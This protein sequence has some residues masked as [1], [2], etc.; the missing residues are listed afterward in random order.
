M[1]MS[2][3]TPNQPF[4]AFPVPS[5]IRLREVCQSDL[6]PLFRHQLDPQANLMAVA[7]PRDLAT[8]TAHWSKILS[9]PGVVARA[10]VADELL[11]GTISCFESDGH[12]EVESGSPRAV[13]FWIAKEHWGRGIATRALGLLIE[14]VTVRPLHARAARSNRASIRVLERNGFV[15]AGYRMSPADDRF[16]ACEE[17]VLVLTNPTVRHSRS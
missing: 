11:V 12:D 14:Q 15:I 9:D 1:P 3:V 4:A 6:P 10:I 13:G 8:F 17:A 2:P 7:H 16:P 5:S